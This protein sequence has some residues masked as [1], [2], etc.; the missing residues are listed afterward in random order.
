MESEIRFMDTLT[1]LEIV[2]EL[3]QQNVMSADDDHD[4]HKRQSV[5]LD[6]V[7]DFVVNNSEALAADKAPHTRHAAMNVLSDRSGIWQETVRKYVGQPESDD[8][9]HVGQVLV[10]TETPA[11]RLN[12]RHDLQNHSPTGFAWGYGGSG[13]AQL[14][15]AILADAT[16]SDELALRYYQTFKFQKIAALDRGAWEIDSAE[17]TAWVEQQSGDDVRTDCGSERRR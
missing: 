9:A 2:Y 12:P 15:L 13:P 8:Y 4:Q 16:G 14:A 6:V 5:A 7:H 3:A 10:V 1:A 11:R 17:V